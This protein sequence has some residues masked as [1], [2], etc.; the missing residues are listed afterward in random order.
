MEFLNM[1]RRLTS[2]EVDHIFE[3]FETF[4]PN[5][6]NQEQRLTII[7]YMQDALREQLAE[8]EIYPEAID[9]LRKQMREMIARA[10]IPPGESVG[11]LCSQSIGERQTQLTLN[12]FHS[13]GL[14]VSTVTT[15]VPRF[16]EVL[17]ATKEPK[18]SINSFL[19]KNKTLTIQQIRQ[20]LGPRLKAVY[21]SDLY[22]TEQI[23]FNKSEEPWYEPFEYL[24]SCDFRFNSHCIS[25][26]L[27][28]N[29]LY[30]YN[31]SLLDIKR[32]IE[33]KF[34]D[35]YVVVSPL[36]YAQVDIFLDVSVILEELQQNDRSFTESSLE[37]NILFQTFLEDIIKP[38]LDEI[39]ICGIPKIKNF[40]IMKE[41]MQ[42]NVYKIEVEG[43]NMYEL[44]KNSNI[45]TQSLKTNN[46]WEVY[47]M[48]GVEATRKFLLEELKSI[49]SSDGTFI[50]P[51][52]LLLLVNIMTFHGQI[53]SVS[54]YGVKKETDSVLAKATFE[55]TLDHFSKAAFFAENET[56]RS[57]SS[58]IMCGKRTKI[59][60]GMNDVIVDWEPFHNYKN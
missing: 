52:H 37:D 42:S 5:F 50:N 22:E 4:F 32:K 24:Y 38:R 10:I 58:S 59:G 30:E 19:L 28:K 9:E 35:I 3:N 56:I 21:F 25:Y 49:V 23:E 7:G 12:S 26:K 16:L 31:I 57:V 6:I 36:S 46:M 11:I 20:L 14:N 17:N 41:M 2:E 8:C 51:C 40:Y 48:L 60:S 44:L 1:K 13:S 45:E 18:A 47:R 54:R 33:N 34:D 15:G 29:V 55:E 39:L 27:R 53:Q 43:N